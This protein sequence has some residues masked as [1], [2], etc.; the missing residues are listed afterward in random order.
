MQKQSPILIFLHGF[1]GSRLD[2]QE[3]IDLI[4]QKNPKLQCLALDLPGQGENKHFIVDNFAEMR[5][6]LKTQLPQD[7]PLV[8]IGYSLGGRVLMDFVLKTNLPNLHAVFFEGANFGLKTEEEKI[9]RLKNDEH[10]AGRFENEDLKNVLN[11]WYQQKVF[12][13]LN[14]KARA[15]VI[16]KRLKNHPQ[17]LAKM[18][19]HLSLAKQDNFMSDKYQSTWKSLPRDSQKFCL[20]GEKDSKFKAL[21]EASGLPFIAIP[22]AG[23][24]AHLENPEAFAE[25]ILNALEN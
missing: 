4:H 19:S 22:N 9:A 23:H 14:E 10:W 5:E 11:D 6:W 2:W 25:A 7:R 20:F 18:L 8:L 3:V 21:I 1:L 13:H 16:E 12:S 17:S 24:N 15:K